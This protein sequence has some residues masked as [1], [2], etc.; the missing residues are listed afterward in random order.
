MTIKT[1][2]RESQSVRLTPALGRRAIYYNIFSAHLTPLFPLS[3]SPSSC[4]GRVGVTPARS[5]W[6]CSGSSAS[7]LPCSTNRPAEKRQWC[8]FKL[9]SVPTHMFPAQSRALLFRGTERQLVTIVGCSWL[10]IS[11]CF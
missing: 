4:Q 9:R 7:A 6:S 8:L 11:P 2:A 10:L 5:E 1:R 3:L